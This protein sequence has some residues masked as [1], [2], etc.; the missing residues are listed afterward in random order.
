MNHG[1]CPQCQST[2]IY[3][4]PATEGEGMSAGGYSSLIEIQVQGKPATLWLNT[5]ICRACGFVELYVANT[6]DLGLL[7]RADGWEKVDRMDRAC[8]TSEWTNLD[9]STP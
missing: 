4:G 6:H 2:D 1:I 3:C 7:S 9:N 5:L 8:R